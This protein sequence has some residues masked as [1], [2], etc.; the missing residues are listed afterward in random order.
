MGVGHAAL[1]LGAA[2]ATPRLNVGWLVFAALLADFLLGIFASMGLESA[3]GQENFATNHYLTFTFPYS[4]GLVPLILWGVIF[5]FL[6]SRT[7]RANRTIV[8][9]VVAA[10]V[11]SHYLLDGLV[12]VA[13]LP[14]AGENSPKLGLGLWK[15][16]PLELTLETLMTVAGVWMYLTLAGI[17]ASAVSRYGVTIFMVVL[18]AL[19]WTQLFSTEAPD[20]AQLIPAWIVAPLL[21]AAVVYALDRKRAAAAATVNP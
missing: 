13:G 19:T 6:V 20:T 16:M 14:I 11:V 18:T 12:H 2:K 3:H 10:A 4:H 17:R 5:G 15:H 7:T 21:F 9:A 8:F 1:A